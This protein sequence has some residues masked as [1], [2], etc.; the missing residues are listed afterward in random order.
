M[1][2]KSF[3]PDIVI[4]EKPLGQFIV[5]SA[6]K[7]GDEIAI[8]DANNGK[9]L[10]YKALREETLRLVALLSKAGLRKGDVVCLAL[11]FDVQY[12]PLFIAIN[13][14]GAVLFGTKLLN[15]TSSYN[16]LAAIKPKLV[17]T[18]NDRLEELSADLKSSVSS[19]KLCLSFD[20]LQNIQPRS[21]ASFDDS[22][23]SNGATDVHKDPVIIYRSGGTTGE[24]KAVVA[25]H[26]KVMAMIH[27]LMAIN[28]GLN[29]GD[30]I[31]SFNPII[32]VQNLISLYYCICQRIKFVYSN[33]SSVEKH[34]ET[35]T[36]YKVNSFGIFNVNILKGI[37]EQSTTDP[38]CDLS[39]L[40]N[41]N[42]LGGTFSPEVIQEARDKLPGIVIALIY[43]LTE[44][45]VV[46]VGTS[47]KM[48]A[49]SAGYLR[50]NIEVKVVD[51]DT[52]KE[53]ECGD[54]GEICV[55][56]P[57]VITDYFEQDGSHIDAIHDGW[58]T[59]GD[60]GYFDKK[61]YIY[62]VGRSADAI[63]IQPGSV[64]VMPAELENILLQHKQ[65]VDVTVARV[66]HSDYGEAPR[67]F[68]VRNDDSLTEEEVLQFFENKTENVISLHGG[69]EFVDVI[70]RSEVGKPLRR[71]LVEKF[72]GQN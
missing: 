46:A 69:V 64:T 1:I 38:E 67:A 62:V 30:V 61:G 37:I 6:E 19:M 42:L 34:L 39:S 20:Q 51:K 15:K 11:P 45:G 65:I 23:P 59:T 36:K 57:Q 13:Y 4:P 35:I 32:H 33:N 10:T 26:Y 9:E 44:A 25:T 28:N 8:A 5:E 27:I 68:V 24:P 2:L 49:S 58:L 60:L 3:F 54:K 52:R 47:N 40:I 72:I 55:R 48:P 41:I 14:C 22:L 70:P 71:K 7:F 18:T 50:N 66:S 17:V 43:A 56:G 21:L 31:A 29:P 12:V 63:K 53:L 16:Q